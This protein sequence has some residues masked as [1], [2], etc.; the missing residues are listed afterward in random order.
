MSEYGIETIP[1][2]AATVTS[3]S[4]RSHELAGERPAPTVRLA[5]AYLRP[6][7]HEAAEVLWLGQRALRPGR[8]HLEGI[9]G[10]AGRASGSSRARRAPDLPLTGC[11]ITSVSFPAGNLLGER[12]L[13]R[14][15]R[16]WR[17][18][19]RCTPEWVRSSLSSGRKKGGPPKPTPGA[20]LGP[21]RTESSNEIEYSPGQLA[22]NARSGVQDHGHGTVVHEL[23][24]HVRA[25]P[26]ALRSRALPDPFIQA[27]RPPPE[28]LLR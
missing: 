25:E 2:S 18:C 16:R 13:R 7:P 3:L 4:L 14:P 21:Q 24:G 15:A 8:G 17:A 5:R 26:A 10:E 23:D 1:W 9:I 22:G 28:A 27:A 19:S 20:A 11:S 6:L 12:A